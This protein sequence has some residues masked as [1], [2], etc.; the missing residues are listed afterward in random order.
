M[1]ERRAEAIASEGAPKAIG[2][3][4]QAIAHGDDVFCSGQIGLDPRTGELVP[5]GTVAE[6]RRA[7]ANL[8]AVLQAAGCDTRDVVRTTLYLVDL[9]DF[10]A[11]NAVYQEAFASPYP[12][13]VT[14]GVASL[15]RGAR[16]EIDAVARRSRT[17]S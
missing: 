5:G 4:S 1:E 14:V 11:V 6:A 17:A 15:P 16:L 2:P 7:L 8:T 13:R 3:Y 10:A 12:A 9:S